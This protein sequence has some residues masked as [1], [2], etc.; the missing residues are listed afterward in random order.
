M[1]AYKQW[2]EVLQIF[3]SAKRNMYM[4]VFIHLYHAEVSPGVQL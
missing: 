4:Q 1:Y 3:I 2:L